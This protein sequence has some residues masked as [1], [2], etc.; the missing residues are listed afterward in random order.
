MR[1]GFMRYEKI[2]AYLADMNTKYKVI[3]MFYAFAVAPAGVMLV[4]L[5]NHSSRELTP[6]VGLYL[7]ALLIVQLPLIG[8]ASSLLTQRNIEKI[9]DYCRNV[10]QGVYE[11]PFDLPPE[12]GDEHDFVRLKR[13]LYWMGRI[14]ANREE[15]LMEALQDLHAVQDR[16]MESIEYA[17]LIQ[18][19]VLPG[20]DVL[21]RSLLD[22]FIWWAPRDVVGGDAYWAVETENGCLAGVID[23]TGHG[24]PG[25]FVT[26]IVNTFLDKAPTRNFDGNP[27]AVL[28]YM[29]RRLKSFLGRNG[30]ESGSDDGLEAA[31]CFISNDRKKLIFAGA[32]LSLF[33]E[34]DGRI[35]EIRGDR[36]GVGY[37][38]VPVDMRYTNREINARKGM[39]IYLATDG[40]YGQV[41]G[42]KRLPLGKSGFKQMISKHRA[43]P[44]HEQKAGMIEDFKAYMGNEDRR[45]DLTVIGFSVQA[46]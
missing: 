25:A 15:R 23:C 27:A 19:A 28:R 11:T 42:A 13:N 7:T 17:G 30:P 24:V 33:C 45:D 22:Y 16:L 38:H 36:A 41:G 43:L 4:F 34:L 8:V 1:G 37:S 44:F 6:Y 21:N 10:K 29:N 46:G 31:L 2:M 9:N 18:R 12:K 20:P 40:V 14:I 3:F 5:S 26:L 32:G 39:R 35:E